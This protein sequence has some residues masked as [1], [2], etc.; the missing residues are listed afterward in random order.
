MFAAVLALALTVRPGDTMSGIAASHGVS[1]A[2]LEAANP[3]VGN[4]N[5]IYAGQALRLPGAGGG[6]V[7]SAGDREPDGDRDDAAPAPARH[8]AAPAH[9]YAGGGYSSASL[10]D[11]P[12]VPRAFAACVALR[13]SSNGA[14]AAY[15][16]GVYGIIRASGINVNGQPLAAQKRAF[17]QLYRQYGTAPW[18]PSDG[19]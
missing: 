7:R 17:S 10:S 8:Y 16:G 4:P 2:A 3:Q 5:L 13:E 18:A 19:C 6:T 12:G 1:L 15:N 14:N 9:V 11:V